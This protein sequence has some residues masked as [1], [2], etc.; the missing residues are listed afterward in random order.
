MKK[1]YFYLALM[2][3]GFTALGQQYTT[4]SFGYIGGQSKVQLNNQTNVQFNYNGG[5]V[6]STDRFKSILPDQAQALV[7]FPAM[8]SYFPDVLDKDLFI[9]KGYFSDYVQLKWN[10]LSQLDKITRIK[11]FRKPLGFNGDSLLISTISPDNFS[12]RDEFA[13]KGVLYKYTLFAEGIA[14]DLRIPYINT[15]EGVGFAFPFG[16]AAGRVTFEG[17]T[18]VEGVQILAETDGN[19]SGRSLMLNGSD[20]YLSIPHGISDNELALES[21]FT[22]QLWARYNGSGKGTLFS[23]G[24]Q[25]ELSYEPGTLS[26]TVGDVSVDMAYDHPVDTFFHIT[27]VHDPSN[28][29]ALYVQKND[30][31]LLSATEGTL[32]TV[33]ADESSVI[34][35]RDFQQ[36]NYFSGYIDELRL[37]NVPLTEAEA[38]S[39]FSRYL[40]GSDDGLVGYWRLNSGISDEFYDFS[41]DGFEF[42]EN[43]GK[44]WRGEWSETVPTKT[45]LAYRGVTDASG[46]YVVRGF[47]YETDGS[48]YTFTPVFDVHSFE[49]TQQ[50]R[51]V[52]DGSSIFNGLDFQD[53]SS[54]PVS[55]TIRYRNSAFTVEGVSILIDGKAAI[56]KDGQLILTDNQGQFTVDVPIGEH[57]IRLSKN[58]HV[59]EGE[60][61]FPPPAEDDEF[62][63]F[64][65]QKALAGLE[66]IDNTVVKFVGKV[67]G[68]PVEAEKPRGFGLSKNNIGNAEIT[69]TTEKGLDISIATDSTEVYEERD[70]NSSAHFNKQRV[71]I[72]PDVVTGEFVA[73]LLPEKHVVE[74]VT[75]GNYTFGDE[76]KVTINLETFFEQ[77]E[78]YEEVVMAF[79]SDGTQVPGYTPYDPDDYDFITEEEILDT[80]YITAGKNF[81]FEKDKDFILRVKPD[82]AVVN[83]AGTD[84]FGESVYQYEDDILESEIAL[85]D[86][87]D[88][89]TFGH[90]VFFQ[91]SRYRMFISVFEEYVN[92][93]LPTNDP[94]R[95][96]RVPVKDGKIEIVNDFGINTEVETLELN[97]SGKV[98]YTFG[99]GFPEINKNITDSELSFTRPLS[100][101]A[102]TGEN[103]NIRT[104]W[105]ENDE[106]RAIVF[107]GVPQGNNFVTT[108]PNQIITILRDPPGSGSYAYLEQGS[109]ATRTVN[110][111]SN[112]STNSSVNAKISLGPKIQT[113]AGIGAG[114]I[115]E[116][117]IKADVSL[118]LS[119]NTSYSQSGQEVNT[120]TS[121]KRWST[122]AASNFVNGPGDVFVGHSTNIVYGEALSLQPVP[123]SSQECAGGLC[124]GVQNGNF[125]LAPRAGLR[126]NPEFGTMFIYTQSHIENTLIPNL[127]EIRNSIL[128]YSENPE[129]VV[130]DDEPIYLSL[131][132]ADD[133]R[134]GSANYNIVHWGDDATVDIGVGPSYSIIL[135]DGYDPALVSDTIAYYN[136][137]IEGWKTALENNE[138]AK[139]NAQLRE[140]I[141]FDG[142]TSY[143][144]SETITSTSS[145]SYD[146]NVGI[147]ASMATSAGVTVA[148]IGTEINISQSVQMGAN[149]G[150][151]SSVANST[152][153]SYTLADGQKSGSTAD[154]YSIDVKTPED[155]FGPVFVTRA[156]V[157]SCPYEGESVTEYFEPG[158]HILNFAT[159]QVEKPEI[160]IVNPQVANVPSN[161][162]AEIL[163]ELKNNSES[164]TDIFYNLKVNDQS[165][166]NGAILS[167]DGSVLTG[168]GR[169]ILVPAGTTVSKILKVSK[170]SDDINEY[171]DIILT[172]SS[173]CDSKIKDSQSFS[174]YFQPG[175]S[176]INLV[177]PVDLWVVNTNTVPEEIQNIV[178]DDYDLQNE[179]FEYVKFQYKAVSSSQWL[180]NMIFYNPRL[181]TPEEFDLLD[182]PKA[183]ISESGSTSYPWD[184]SDLPDRRFDIRVVSVCDIAPGQTAETPSLTHTGIKDTKRPLVFGAPQPA[185]G[186][187]SANDEIKLQ[188]DETIEAGLLTPFNFSVQ[189]VLNSAK[190]RHSASVNFDGDN[191][192]VKIEDGLSLANRS[193]TI[194]FWVNRRNFAKEQVLFSKGR[195][196]AD[197]LE[198]GFAADSRFFINAGGQLTTSVLPYPDDQWSH[199]AIVYT[200]Q[201]NELTVHK[202]GQPVIAQASVAGS[203]S[204]EGAITLGKSLF[205][206][207][208]ELD[209]NM[210]ELR[211]WTQTK[212]QGD[213]FA[214]MNASMTGSEVGLIGYWPMDEAIGN[215]AFDKARFRH[216]LLFAD[217]EVSPKGN[218]FAF[219]GVD[220]LLTLNTGSTVVITD[221]MDY[222]IEFWFK[223][224]AQANTVMFSSGRG[225]GLDEFNDPA[226]SLSIGFDESGELYYLHNGT[227]MSA[228]EDYLDENWHHFAF[229]LSR[230]SNANLFVDGQQKAT[231]VASNFGGVSGASMWVGARGYKTSSVI[232][233]YDQYFAG[234]I[235]EFRVW[236]MGKKSDQINLDINSRLNGDE[237]GLVGYYP[238][239]YYETVNGI[240]IM[241]STLD[242]QW[243]NPYGPNAGASTPSGG[244]DFTDDTP[245]IKDARPVEKIDF[246]WVVND[247]QIIIT[248]ASIF[249]P[250]IEQTTLEITIREI[251][252]LYENRMASPVT[253]TAFIDRNQ[254]KWE[255]DQ[256]IA[257]KQVYEPYSFIMDVFNLGGTEESFTIDNLP[258]W[259]TAS[260]A[261]GVLAPVSSQTITFTVDEGLNTGYYLE[262]IY[263]SSDFGF[264]EKLILDLQVFSPAPDW[265]TDP[266]GF[267]Y[268]MNFIAQ[269]EV[270]NIISTDINDRVAAFVNGEIRGDA[271]LIY[272]E[273]FDLYTVYLDIYSN[274]ESGETI[275]LRVWDASAGVEYRQ[276]LPQISF[277]ANQVQG[278]P[279]A[280]EL[281][282]AGNT[283]VQEVNFRTGWNWVSFNLGSAILSDIDALMANINA[284]T[285]DQ[286]KG[287]DKVDVYTDQIGWLG[288]I[289]D[290][291]GLQDGAMY[292][293]KITNAGSIELIGNPIPA[294]TEL[295]ISEGW[296][297]IGFTPRFNMTLNEAFAFF[298]P[299][300]GDVIKSQFAFS[301]YQE[302]I[303]WVGSLRNLEPGKGYLFSS[304]KAGT[305]RFPESTFLS[306]RVAYEP[307]LITQFDE[308]D[309]F[310]YP[311]N[312]SVIATIE[313]LEEGYTLLA[314]YGDEV[315][316][317]IEPISIGDHDPLYF[318][319]IYG[320]Q[321]TEAIS[322]EALDPAT[323]E[324]IS[325]D[326][327]VVFNQ[328]QHLGSMASPVALKLGN[329]L[330]PILDLAVYP[331]PF[332]DE[333]TV[334]LPKTSELLPEMTLVNLTGQTLGR[335]QVIDQGNKWSAVVNSN[336]MKLQPGLYIIR[337]MLDQRYYDFKIIKQ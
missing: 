186:V 90:P 325:L 187:L 179:Q 205:A 99:A 246:D 59:F 40:S 201:D 217:W 119:L 200:A 227:K 222:T 175:C 38:K 311:N 19:L 84:I 147:T 245:N 85:I 256:V 230:Q 189:G 224:A 271:N 120:I 1:I 237:I 212:S 260:P 121:T 292:L 333:L 165:N 6:I 300:H 252:D 243:I 10:I 279:S 60:G 228:A 104:T 95:S 15:I 50:L 113:W 257:Q 79:L 91:Q 67:V 109:T 129:T 321:N 83:E 156:G 160:T 291:G 146:F 123:L 31:E 76:H 285:G 132:P 155:G 274:V 71:T 293:F 295:A 26:F 215:K 168:D 223:G 327:Q 49:P 202:N 182:E 69:L 44:V 307:N 107:G 199:Y 312:M 251:Q 220:D 20:A 309:R 92:I 250:L 106:F 101:I 317:V 53:V 25:Y 221:E 151:G 190:I 174:V 65:F 111:G 206:A 96:D 136:K 166:F 128:S 331:N 108:G 130:A 294:S 149:E 326:G 152:T 262:D 219:D 11:I 324:T 313:G 137:Q 283:N 214:K 211:I 9:S 167:I 319:T 330:D 75:A 70:I 150:G 103:A 43:H 54:F 290:N 161:R 225:D 157:T 124:D 236:N 134:F 183:W 112:I 46:N 248:P 94:N 35:G 306:G 231:M 254:L 141:S 234:N 198:F 178:F 114:V 336:R 163:L 23:K 239:E 278:S 131:V 148:G 154:Y 77:T 4:H 296:N 280:P 269:L 87:D 171:E 97:E 98:T 63:T 191:D 22:I 118:G 277:T 138:R 303:G 270:E 266:F 218:A 27:A 42:F 188:F 102:V 32:P 258:Q 177:A 185:D 305:F 184:M 86:E 12:Y 299:S 322:F 159:V 197:A 263:L 180:T 286:I 302:G 276:A 268:S 241:N 337:V 28:G 235:D 116:S 176:D 125:K 56:D 45:Q 203:F 315:R 298:T 320:H 282:I 115:N 316:G 21:G 127:I 143:S 169:G 81:I 30:F 288:S 68:G 14:D 17:G 329:E 170:G 117:K 314:K 265:D 173:Q 3:F 232:T 335:L 100:L 255:D 82:I 74:N 209:G 13:E 133:E 249:A 196:A 289:S 204:G 47:P 318:I 273:A 7:G 5:D 34:F 52:G 110:W 194:E 253:W 126:L 247:D 64:N 242:D 145:F 301:I 55:G 153:Y 308:L 2:L 36:A 61:R 80:T 8:V 287:Q 193:F 73:Y 304:T 323:G 310:K 233:A 297:W 78:T 158:E 33:N 284:V 328:A 229:T 192:Y 172:L 48:Q 66:F 51:F 29:L 72:R 144:S 18:A 39:N 41:R 89:Y 164:E 58:G 16:T 162:A 261:S 93:D 105:R 264:D 62:P 267:Q 135:P 216:A 272:L 140:N 238:F 334:E 195:S 259:L 208:S 181:V 210:H 332:S 213:V 244:A 24:D 139:V 57:S 142:G 240:Q 88:N 37:W 281:I 275:E 207:G 122:S 226:N